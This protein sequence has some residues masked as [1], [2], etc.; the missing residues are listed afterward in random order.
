MKR[1][2]PNGCRFG[3]EGIVTHHGRLFL[4]SFEE[5][6][7]W[8]EREGKRMFEVLLVHLSPG[9]RRCGG[10][11]KEIQCEEVRNILKYKI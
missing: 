1:C 4:L 6:F 8:C 3:K 7:W 10:R 2:I 11:H 9:R 5:I